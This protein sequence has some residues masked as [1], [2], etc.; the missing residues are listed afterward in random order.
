MAWTWAE[1][2][3]CSP[4]IS[5]LCLWIGQPL[6]HNASYTHPFPQ[7][8]AGTSDRGV[9]HPHSTQAL[10]PQELVNPHYLDHVV[11]TGKTHKVEASEDIVAGNGMKLLAKGALIDAEVKDRLLQHKLRK[12]L[13]DCIQVAGG[14]TE[15]LGVAADALMQRYPFL[16]ALCAEKSSEPPSRTIAKLK[17]TPPMQSLL[18][19]YCEYREDKLDHAVSVALLARG[20]AR[21][22][23]PDRTEV[24]TALMLSGLFHDVGELYINPEYL[25]KGVRLA[26]AQWRHIVTH[27]IVAHRLL[28]EMAG[29]GP[30]VADPVLQHHERLD[31]FGYPFGLQG[32]RLSLPG[33]ILACAELLVGIM[34]SAPRPMSR[35]AI[36]MRLIPGE[37]A[38][39][40]I[41]IVASAAQSEQ[42]D[43]SKRD[44]TSLQD[45]LPRVERIGA[46]LQRFHAGQGVLLQQMQSVSEKMQPV[47]AQGISRLRSIQVAFSSTGM[48]NGDPEQL[49]LHLGHQLDADMHLELTTIL[50]EIEW[51]LRELERESLHRAE[52]ISA[53]ELPIVQQLIKLL[54]GR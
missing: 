20:L 44:T 43:G 12:P 48:N 52:L 45:N 16:P 46:T 49:L 13:E 37:F 23:I 25:A 34:E 10:N 24:H 36:A 30:V 2:L 9:W 11:A 50:R 7:E 3:S 42:L 6:H 40:L 41:D 35:A 18:T 51:R 22:L 39:G 4:A 32:E 28:K 21:K 38:R 53:A 54:K 14:V 8:F 47:I 19:V 33:Q 17:F 29:A 27:P 1:F 31:G 15:R 26:P 5:P